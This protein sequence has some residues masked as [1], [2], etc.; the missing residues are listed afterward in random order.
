[1][2]L[3]VKARSAIDGFAAIWSFDNRVELIARRLLFRQTGLL[4]YR[5]GDMEIVVDHHAGDETGTR[6]CLVSDMYLR[7]LPRMDLHAPITVFDIGANGGGFPLM[8]ESAG[9]HVGRLAAVEM[10]PRTFGRMQLNV[11]QNLDCESM[12]MNAAISDEDGM[13]TLSLSRGSTGESI[14]GTRNASAFGSRRT[15]KIEAISFDTAFERGFGAAGIVDLCK[16][17]VEGA[18]YQIFAGHRFG[19]LARC[20]YLIIEIHD[21]P[22]QSPETVVRAIRDAGFREVEGS[23]KTHD[24][25]YLFENLSPPAH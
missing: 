9:L 4:T 13:L 23:R 6:E 3:A 19:H 24:D 14:S 25:V 21:V 17:D 16:L 5:K 8:L 15:S 22:G 12:L 7:L 10:N 1:M 11:L 20:R 2:A 18:E